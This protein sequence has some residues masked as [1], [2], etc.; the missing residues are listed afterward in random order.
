MADIGTVSK[1]NNSED[2]KNIC[3]IHFFNAIAIII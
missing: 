1:N 2:Y 3:I